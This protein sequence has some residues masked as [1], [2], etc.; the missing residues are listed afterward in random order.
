MPRTD[1]HRRQIYIQQPN[2]NFA[3]SLLLTEKHFR[4][5]HYD[6]SVVYATPLLDIHKDASLFVQ[7]VLGL[8]SPNECHLGLDTSVQWR[9]DA[10]S[11]RKVSGTVE[12]SKFDEVTKAPSTLV[13]E[14]DMSEPPFLRPGIHGRGTVGWH[15]KDPA[16]GEGV[17]VKDI[18]HTDS[19]VSEC[20][21][22]Q[23]AQGIPGIVELLAS[24]NNCA[25]TQQY[26]P[27]GLPNPEYHNRC[28]LRV[29]VK[30]YGLP[31]WYFRSRIQ[32]LRALRDTLIGERPFPTSTVVS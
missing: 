30:K 19:R 24:Q 18:W 21:Y 2:R 17:L 10:R 4:L 9:I 25:E 11:G 16:T 13:Y 14:L 15:A 5:V 1:S 7:F 31:L 8:T 6:R 3:R 22:L 12:L 26:L 23:A 27:P 32:L 29:A 28:K 20:E